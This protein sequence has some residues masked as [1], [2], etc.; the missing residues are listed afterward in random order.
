MV[1]Y[2]GKKYRSKFR[3][4][5]VLQKDIEGAMTRLSSWERLKLVNAVKLLSNEEKSI[6]E[7]ERFF[8][9]DNRK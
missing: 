9:R 7:Q 5:E 3:V 2:R 8:K 6:I 4:R 1:E